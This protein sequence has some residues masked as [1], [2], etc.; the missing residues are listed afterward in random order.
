MPAGFRSCMKESKS[1][2]SERWDEMRTVQLWRDGEVRIVGDFGRE[3]GKSE[4]SFEE[5]CQKYISMGYEE[6]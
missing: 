4:M 5:T 2:Y 3:L 1:F 6:V